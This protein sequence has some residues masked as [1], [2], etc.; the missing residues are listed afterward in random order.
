MDNGPGL[1]SSGNEQ[2]STQVTQEHWRVKQLFQSAL[3]RVSDQRAAYLHEACAGDEAL[4]REVESLLSGEKA[5][6]GF[7]EAPA[8]EAATKMFSED[9]SQSLIGRQLGSYQVLSLLGAGGMGEVYQAHDTKLGRNVAI[10]VLPATFIHDPQRLARFQ[11]EARTLASLNHPNIATIYGLEQSGGLHYLVM[12]LIPGQTLAERVSDG[13]LGIKEALEICGQI[14]EALEVA[15]EKGVIHRDLKPANV[16]VTPEGRVKVLDFGLAKAFGGDSRLDLSNTPTLTAM[17]TE[18]GR[19]LGTPAYMSPEQ[20][21]GKPVDTRTDIWAFGCVLYEL[22]TGKRAFRGETLQDTIAAVLEREPEWQALPPSTSAKIVGLLRRCMQKD[23][24]YRLRDLGDARIEIEEALA[25]AARRGRRGHTLFRAAGLAAVALLIG[26]GVMRFY[27]AKATTTVP[28][29]YTQITNFT[30]SVTAPSL[31]PDGRMLAFIRGGT[32]FRSRGQIYVKLLPNSESVRLTKEPGLKYAPVF[33]SDGSR[34]AYTLLEPSG[35][36]ISWD[37][38]TVPV[39]GGQPT[40]LLQNASG[41]TWISDR[42]VLFSEIKTGLHMGIVTSTEEREQR[43][44]IYFPAHERAMAHYSYLSPNHREVLVVEMDRTAQ[45][46]PCRLV[47]FDGT[48]PGRPVGPSGKC[49]SAGWSPDGKWMYFG[50]EVEGSSHLWRQ[51]F[52]NGRP[53]QITFG[54][55]EEDGIAVAPDG[56][57]LITSIGIHQSSIWIHAAAGDRQISSE[58]FASVPRLSADGKRVYYL[59]GQSSTASSSELRMV[60][61]NSGKTDYFLPGFSITDYDISQDE[62]KVVFAATRNGGESEIWMA[63]LDRHSPPRQIT[64]GG[65]QVSFGANGEIIFRLLGEKADYP[66][67]IKQDGSGRE[68]IANMPIS[69][70]FGVSPN[71]EWVIAWA[72]PRSGEGLSAETVAIPVRGG[73]PKKIC[74]EFCPTRWSSDGKFLYVGIGQNADF[75]TTQYKTLVIPLPLGGSLSEL[76]ATG[77]GPADSGG[78]LPGTRVIE[79]GRL[80]PGPDPSTYVFEKTDLQR[81]L[82]RIPLH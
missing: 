17:G 74:S 48:S 40:R 2:G 34:V 59:S 55:T 35:D 54:P 13:P 78:G 68:P 32:A 19:I 10:K 25:L 62:T 1:A 49:T 33:T 56:H 11:R 63:S 61:V 16:K 28:S 7:L 47:P 77:I 42:A 79:R 23:P 53:Q 75:S 45:W 65:D 30:D 50:A 46:Q 57:S 15:H 21:R 76:P 66:Y 8:L 31:S 60:D 38:W 18:E 37:T 82:F 20:A 64:R 41:L 81:N 52:P 43:R 24:Q 29:E 39:L 70:V 80:F 9:P 4:R 6:D 26:I 3:E 72:P 58:G 69:N 51:Q 36:S 12:E 22:L 67:R 14:A 44:E 27:S 73:T 71:G 5:L